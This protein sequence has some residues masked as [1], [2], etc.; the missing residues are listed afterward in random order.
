MFY[1]PRFGS[2]SPMNLRVR[3]RTIK[4]E[5][6]WIQRLHWVIDKRKKNHFIRRKNLEHELGTNAHHYKRTWNNF[7]K[8]CNAIRRTES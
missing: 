5:K 8:S 4:A 7:E 3:Y 6:R 2:Y 1:L